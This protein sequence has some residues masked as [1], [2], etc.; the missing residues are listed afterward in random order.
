M[1]FAVSFIAGA[2]V[3]G[4]AF[5]MSIRILEPHNSENSLGLAL[6]VGAVVGVFGSLGGPVLGYIPLIALFYLLIR[7]Y[8]LGFIKSILV[9]VISKILTELTF[10]LVIGLINA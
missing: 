8:D 3:F 5:W 1:L 9:L 6:V 7:H 4:F 10:G 2:L